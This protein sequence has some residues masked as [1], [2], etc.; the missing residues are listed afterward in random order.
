MQAKWPIS[1]ISYQGFEDNTYRLFCC[2]L[3]YLSTLSG[4]PHSKPTH[5]YD[6]EKD[7]PDFC[8]TCLETMSAKD[9]QSTLAISE[10]GSALKAKFQYLF[11][12]AAIYACGTKYTLHEGV[13]NV[14]F[15]T[16]I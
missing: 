4:G 8:Q 3:Y 7:L 12:A 9:L 13:G 11:N 5:F 16:K 6:A 1:E 2:R 14:S 15:A 10:D